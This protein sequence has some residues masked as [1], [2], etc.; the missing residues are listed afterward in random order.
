MDLMARTKPP[1]QLLHPKFHAP[2]YMVD[3]VT[4]LAGQFHLPPYNAEEQAAIGEA[5]VAADKSGKQTRADLVFPNLL[6]GNMYAAQDARYLAIQVHHVLHKNPIPDI[7]HFFTRA[8]F[9]ENK[10]C[11]EKT[12]KLRQNTQKNAN[13]LHYYGKIH[14]K[15]SIFRVKSVRIYTDQKNLHEY[16]RGVRDKYQV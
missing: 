1:K 16:I 5:K 2:P 14:S 4:K 10:I 13:F 6:I 8:K 11:T 9:L 12:C 3:P 15:L 7:C